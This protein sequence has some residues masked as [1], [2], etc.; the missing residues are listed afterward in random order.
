MLL[1]APARAAPNASVRCLAGS[2]R[3]NEADVFALV[4]PEWHR[5]RRHWK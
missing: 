3:R 2:C 4:S 1:S 5:F